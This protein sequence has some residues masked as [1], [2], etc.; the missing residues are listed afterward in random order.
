MLP[1]PSYYNQLWR[2]PWPT[3]LPC[4]SWT[5]KDGSC[6]RLTSHT[7][8][9][10]YLGR[11]QLSNAFVRI[12]PQT[13][14]LTSQDAGEK[15]KEEKNLLVASKYEDAGRH[16]QKA[17]P[18]TPTKA[19]ENEQGQHHRIHPPKETPLPNPSSPSVSHPATQ[20]IL[21]NDRIWSEIRAKT[22]HRQIKGDEYPLYTE[23]IKKIIQS[24][25]KWSEHPCGKRLKQTI[26][27]Y[28]PFIE[29]TSKS[30]V[31]SMPTQSLTAVREWKRILPGPWRSQMIIPSGLP[32][33]PFGKK[34]SIKR[35]KPWGAD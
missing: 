11:D 6:T 32:T 28:C 24:I 27:L 22:T 10:I 26:P 25:W 23:P 18:A 15:S 1:N 30:Q 13:C 7:P 3:R 8:R 33:V 29:D 14:W 16:E 34:G 21:W 5:S 31:I 35:A 20:P 17:Q 4:L 12:S 9:V 19:L 2:Q